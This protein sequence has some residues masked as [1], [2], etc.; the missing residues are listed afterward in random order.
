MYQNINAAP[1]REDNQ[2][3]KGVLQVED[4]NVTVQDLEQVPRHFITLSRKIAASLQSVATDEIGRKITQMTESYV[5]QGEAIPGLVI[6]REIVSYYSTDRRAEVIFKITDLGR[7]QVKEGDLESFQN[8][9]NYV[10]SGMRAPPDDEVLEHF[11]YEAIKSQRCLAE[12]IAHYERLEDDSGGDRSYA[13]LYNAVDRYLRRR[14]HRQ[15]RMDLS[16][17]Y[18]ESGIYD[19]VNLVVPVRGRRDARRGDSDGENERRQPAASAKSREA[20]AKSE[21]RT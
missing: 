17:A 8:S 1:G 9:W 13:F 11:Y 21:P 15:V 18:G 14:R 2:A 16:S 5:K 6:L 7:V 10:L 19:P 20:R 4:E 3:L 12:D